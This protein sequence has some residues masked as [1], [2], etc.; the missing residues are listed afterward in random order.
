M[1]LTNKFHR[2]DLR[3]IVAAIRK[4]ELELRGYDKEINMEKLKFEGK[5]MLVPN[6][7]YHRALNSI[8]NGSDSLN[9]T[10]ATKINFNDIARFVLYGLSSEE[11]ELCDCETSGGNCPY[12]AYGFSKCEKKKNLRGIKH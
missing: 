2:I 8:L 12:S 4:K 5:N 7:F 10:E 6:W 1:I 11:S 3:E 9:K